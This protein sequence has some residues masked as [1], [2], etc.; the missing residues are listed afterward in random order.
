LDW[1]EDRNDVL[2]NILFW[3]EEMVGKKKENKKWDRFSWE[4]V[5]EKVCNLFDWFIGIIKVYI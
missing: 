5:N 4:K 2:Y 3:I 1:R